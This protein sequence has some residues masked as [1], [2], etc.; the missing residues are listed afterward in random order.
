MTTH[1]IPNGAFLDAELD[2]GL[3]MLRQVPATQQ[4]VVSPISV[5][6][7]LAMVQIGARGKTRM[8]INQAISRGAADEAI[9]KYYS[10][11]YK[12]IVTSSNG[13]Q[14]RIANGLFIE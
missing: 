7:A 11:L 2:F 1:L 3:S 8:Q 5:I 6:F 12:E 10:K 13:T 14:A 9:I 4:L